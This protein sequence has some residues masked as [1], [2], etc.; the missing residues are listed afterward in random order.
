MQTEDSLPRLRNEAQSGGPMALFRLAAALVLAQ[1]TEEAFDI[2]GRAFSAGLVDAGVERGRMLLHGVGA[3]R[4]VMQAV[5]SFERA[6]AQGSP[7]AGYYLALIAV[8]DLG[9]PFDERCDRRL[10]AAVNAGYPLALRAAAVHFGR[11]PD[12]GDQSLCMRLLSDA[13]AAG[14]AVSAQLLHERLARGEGG[15]V[16]REAAARLSGA[17][18]AQGVPTL[19]E[20]KARS[21]QQLPAPARDLFIGDVMY[22]PD[23]QRL[24]ERPHVLSIERLLSAD[25]CRL[26]IATSL[27]RLQRSRAIDP[28][29]GQPEKVEIRTSSD[30]SLD[31]MLE[32]LSLRLLQRRLATAAG[33]DLVQAEHLT[34]LR[35]LPGEQYRPHRDYRPPGSLERDHPEAGNRLRTICAYLNPVA[36]G[37]GTEFPHAGLIVQPTA[38]SAVVFDNLHPDGT[39]DPESLHAGLPVLAGEKWLATLWFRERRYRH[40]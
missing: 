26:L 40:F 38:G 15:P 4:D 20:V 3:P 13:A 9:L 30:A 25:E 21:P 10:M 36:A 33:V 19:P 32:D 39:P 27:P 17:L 22:G 8:G 29:T 23:R 6:E 1:Q 24:S 2:Y 35:Y 31:P 18:A 37:G 16:Q 5:A 11:K 34:V 12:H 14:D 7:V 28:A